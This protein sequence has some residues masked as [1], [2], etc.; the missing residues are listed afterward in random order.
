[1]KKFYT[2]IYLSLFTIV[3]FQAWYISDLKSTIN[4][5]E[6]NENSWITKYIQ[7]RAKSANLLSDRDNFHL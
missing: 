3:C 1:M 2:A 6:C 5:M 4:H 7:E